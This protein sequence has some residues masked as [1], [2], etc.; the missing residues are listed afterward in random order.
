MK[1]GDAAPVRTVPA[2]DWPADLRAAW[3]DARS[4]GATRFDDEGAAAHWA[5]DTAE[6]VEAVV[7]LFIGW[8]ATTDRRRVRFTSADVD[9]FLTSLEQERQLAATTIA[10]HAVGLFLF[11]RVTEID[12]ELTALRASANRWT[13]IAKRAPKP[14]ANRKRIVALDRLESLGRDLVAQARRRPRRGVYAAVTYRDGLM[15]LFLARRALRRKNMMQLDPKHLVLEDGGSWLRFDADEMKGGRE[16]ELDIQVLRPLIDEYLDDWR[17]LFPHAREGGPMWPSQYRASLHPKAASK[18]IGDITEARLGIRVTMHYFRHAVAT[19]TAER[20][21]NGHAVGTAILGHA[22]G[23]VT[24]DFYRVY[25]QALEAQRIAEN[26][27]E[28]QLSDRDLARAL[29]GKL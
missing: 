29:R 18:R 5:L 25:A 26:I 24:D 23:G 9:A 13:Q 6:I 28:R 3:I 27:L 1:T 4:A 22:N 21:R 11:A 14:L 19:T 16:L 17:P 7:G 2:A 8:L 12:A 20:L 15:I 10:K